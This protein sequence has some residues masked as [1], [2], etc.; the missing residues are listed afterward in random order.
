MSRTATLLALLLAL[1]PRGSAQDP[2]EPATI[3]VT[4]AE[5]TVDLVVRDEKGRLVLDLKP[6]EVEVYE[7]GVLQ[8]V[9]LF[10]LVTRDVLE[11]AKPRAPE[12]PGGEPPPTA[13]AS[14]PPDVAQGAVVALVFDRLGPEARRTAFDAA[15]EWVKLPAVTRRQVG[16]FRIDQG[17]E[18]LQ[19]FTDDRA[20]V[21][22]ALDHV[23]TSQPTSYRSEED[24]ERLRTLRQ[25]HHLRAMELSMLQATEALE[26]DQQG[27]ATTNTLLGLVNGL[28]VVPGRKALV[29]FS[30]GLVLPERE[31]DSLR[32][33]ISE[34][35]RGGVSF[36]AAD[37]ARNEDLLR[38]DPAAGFGTLARDTGGFLIFDTN[39]I[40]AGL[41]RVEEELGAY[42]LLSYAPA[43]EEW[44]GGYRRIEVRVRR[45]GLEVQGRQGYFAV[46]TA[47]PTPILEHEAPVLANLER[48]PAADEIPLRVSALQFPDEYGDSV[49]AMVADLPAGGPSLRPA[50]GDDSTWAQDF[51]VLALIRNEAERIVHKS[52]RRYVLSWGEERLDDVQVGRVL[53]EREALLSPGRYTIE[54]VARDAQSGAMGVARLALELPPASDDELR[55]SSLMVVGHAEPHA[56]GD[57]SP[58][59]Y[60]GVQLYPNLGDPVSRDQGQPLTF[61]FTLRP[62]ARALAAAT[63]ELWQGDTSVLQ[64]SI[65]LPS[66]DPSGQMRVVSGLKLDALEPGPYVLR[67]RVINA[68]GFQTR[69]T[70]FTLGPFRAPGLREPR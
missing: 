37:A 41:R 10:R 49:V 21:R 51:T 17:L 33:V 36:Y 18:M 47:T 52:S 59:F 67:L 25:E 55:V 23:L 61:L 69:S 9:E 12:G 58:L 13:P 15:T 50:E 32:T 5:V 60:E 48:T 11:D 44:D 45:T 46:R 66:P 22:E 34:A 20:A 30:D 70:P 57:P 39:N 8:E 3:A 40:S 31:V 28:R 4:A 53:F 29:F 43:N 68:Q 2:E 56:T 16:V 65:A 27:L 24:R 42:Y 62:G 26:R 6:E 54:I 64:S 38:L 14:R 19:D 63:V 35:N 7:D 1:L